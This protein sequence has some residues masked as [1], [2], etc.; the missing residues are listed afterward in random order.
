MLPHLKSWTKQE[1]E[2][3]RKAFDEDSRQ[4]KLAM[5]KQPRLTRE[6]ILA[7]LRQ[8]QATAP[9]GTTNAAD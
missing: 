4:R 6:E 3:A 8:M 1:K 5:Q 2:A 7:R 9:A